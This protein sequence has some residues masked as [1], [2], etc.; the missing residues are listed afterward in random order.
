MP[1]SA[2][3]V[4]FAAALSIACSV[5]CAFAE[6]VTC[7]ARIQHGVL[8]SDLDCSGVDTAVLIADGGDLDLAGHTLVMGTVAGISCERR[9]SIDGNTAITRGLAS[10]NDDKGTL[11]GSSAGGIFS[12]NPR[13]F[14]KVANLDVTGITTTGL[15]ASRASLVNVLLQGATQ[16]GIETDKRV[17]LQDSTVSSSDLGIGIRARRGVSLEASSVT[18][19]NYG[20]LAG[21]DVAMSGHSTVQGCNIT[22]IRARAVRGTDSQINLSG[23]G[24]WSEAYC[25]AHPE[26]CVDILTV[27]PPKLAGTVCGKSGRLTALPDGSGFEPSGQSWNVCS[28]E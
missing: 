9:C 5:P 16:V 20:I 4:L 1:R 13:S 2:R 12:D 22:G 18:S 7:G 26:D 23:Q 10:T 14:V 6:T 15:T 25:L 8:A 28:S 3:S 27:T 24:P 11:A 19:G 17:T 21:S